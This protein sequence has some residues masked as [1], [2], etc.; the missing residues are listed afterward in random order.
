MRRVRNV[1]VFCLLLAIYHTGFCLREDSKQ[2][3]YIVADYSIYNYKT[4]VNRYEGH[5]KVD[6][7]TTHIT[8]DRLVTKNNSQ[9]KMQEA[10]AYGLIDR[11]H[12]WTLPKVNDPLIHAFANV[13]KF[14]PIESNVTLQK[15]VFVQQGDNTFQGELILYNNYDETITVPPSQNGHAVVVYNPDKQDK[16]G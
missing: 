4:G 16:V 9:H 13:I 12:Y 14:Y 2:K 11:A 8:A 6:Q 15:N 7:G 5:V 10:T 1:I 3:V